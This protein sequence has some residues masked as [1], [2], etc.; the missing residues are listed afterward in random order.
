MDRIVEVQ[1]FTW[2]ETKMVMRQLLLVVD[3]LHKHGIIHKD[4]KPENILLVRDD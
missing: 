4:L 2:E 3:F 1:E